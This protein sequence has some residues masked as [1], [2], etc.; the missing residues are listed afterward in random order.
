MFLKFLPDDQTQKNYQEAVGLFKTYAMCVYKLSSEL[1]SN[2][3]LIQFIYRDIKG[4]DPE[5]TRT[6]RTLLKT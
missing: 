5:A 4:N 3:S 6:E 1:K 2:P